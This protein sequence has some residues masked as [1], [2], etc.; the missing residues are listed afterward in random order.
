MKTLVCV[1]SETRAHKT[2]WP[3]FQKNVLEALNADL[4]VCIATDEKYDENNPFWQNSKYKWTCPEYDD[5][6]Y[7]FE[8]ARDTDWPNSNSNW[9]KMLKIKDQWLGGIKG[10]EEHP[11]AAGILIFFRW[12]LWKNI[13]LH[14]IFAEYDRIV[15]TRSDFIWTCA[16]PPMHILDPN[17]IWIP[18]GE[19]YAG[20][21][22][23]HAVLSKENAEAYLNIIKPIF[24]DTDSLFNQMQNYRSWNLERYINLIIQ[25]TLGKYKVGYFPYM[26][27]SIRERDDSSRWSAGT[28]DEELGYAIKYPTE[29]KIANY[30]SIWIK[31]KEEWNDQM[32]ASSMLSL[33]YYGPL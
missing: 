25:A 9:R 13:Q 7:A 23:R 8:L 30:W 15:I 11:A 20:I 14:N 1:I 29:Y 28:F 24:T 21:T 17:F 4:A 6:G 10:A 12:F 5:W 32:F 33:K 26:M 31:N 27:Y 22:D 16:H 3:S 18:N 2:T 19:H